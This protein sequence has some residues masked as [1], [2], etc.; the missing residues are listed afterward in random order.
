[1]TEKQGS[2]IA[3]AAGA[4]LAVPFV[5]VPASL[6]LL[7]GSKEDEAATCAPGH[8]TPAL[9]V[10]GTIPDR[11]GDYDRAALERAAVIMQIG[12]DLGFSARG[13]LI[14][15]M[16]AMQESTLG[17]D[18]AHTR[19]DE[20][21]DAGVFQQRILDGWYGTLEQVNDLTYATTAFYKGVTAKSPGDYGSVGGTA[22]SP[23]GHIR[24][25]ADIPN[26]ESLALT[27][28]AQAVQGSQYPNAYAKRQT[29]AEKIMSALA[30]VDVTITGSCTGS[31]TIVNGDVQAVIDRGKSII[32]T[33]YDLGSG[34][35]DGP[36]PDGI[37]C[38]A[39]VAYAWTAAGY[40]DLP[41]V[42]QDQFDFL[43]A[44]PVTV[45]DVQ[46][47]DLIYEA[48]GRTGSVG[49][50]SA[51]SHVTMYIGNDQVIEASRSAKQVR[52]SPAR[53]NVSAFVGI[54]RIPAS[55]AEKTPQ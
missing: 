10:A 54:R 39:F 31:T 5:M 45:D 16:T 15:I 9:T 13:Q 7:S 49:S 3:I 26:W 20:N 43:A 38:S 12:K 14:A 24:G 19:P 42:A 51:I 40:R 25:L 6:L 28:A 27:D 21:S 8:G 22:K 18:P 41:R 23:H 47:G 17:M 11:I 32:G 4:V 37:D 29:V 30:G 44:Y 46:P 33:P 36:G 53:W 55:P 1:M 50:P 52:I 2:G 34:T 48:W 35:M